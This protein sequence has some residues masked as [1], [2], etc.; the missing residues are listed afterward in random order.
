[1]CQWLRIMLNEFPD[2]VTPFSLSGLKF[3]EEKA[4][5][6]RHNRKKLR[7]NNFTHAHRFD[8]FYKPSVMFLQNF[9]L[10]SSMQFH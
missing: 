7:V 10:V 5:T 2:Q 6:W 9:Q 1:M 4:S 8:I 3:F